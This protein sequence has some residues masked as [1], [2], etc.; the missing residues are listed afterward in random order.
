MLSRESGRRTTV[1]NRCNKMAIKVLNI[2][3]RLSGVVGVVF[4][5]FRQLRHAGCRNTQ[6]ES[7]RIVDTHS[8]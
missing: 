6:V 5:V 3:Q 1:A 2:I 8:P 7:L 4:S